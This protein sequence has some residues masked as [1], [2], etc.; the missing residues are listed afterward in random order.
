MK[1]YVES[2]FVLE[3]AFLQEEHDACQ[4]LLHLAETHQIQLVI[5]MYSLIEPYEVLVRR[6][7][8]RRDLHTRLMAEI[9]ELARSAPYRSTPVDFQDITGLLLRSEAEEKQRLNQVLMRISAVANLIPMNSNVIQ[10]ATAMQ[11]NLSFSPQD[12]VVY[13]S[14]LDDLTASP[15]LGCFITKNSKD[16]ANPDIE[17]E[18]ANYQC[19]LLWKFGDGLGY[20]KS[21]L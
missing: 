10:I 4:E 5:P 12:A 8:Q 17:Q 21:R 16:F 11:S 2:N 6:T 14:V 9:R 18:L 7:K 1:V 13:A 15:Q 20:M 19:Q 3:L